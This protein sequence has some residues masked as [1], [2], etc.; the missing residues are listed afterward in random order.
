MTDHGTTSQEHWPVRFGARLRAAREFRDIPRTTLE[1]S[2]GVARGML[3]RWERGDVDP[4]FGRVVLLARLYGV[5]LDWLSGAD[6]VV[7]N[8]SSGGTWPDGRGGLSAG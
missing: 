4:G 2:L 1:A 8:R 7:Q 6:L 3:E 5:S